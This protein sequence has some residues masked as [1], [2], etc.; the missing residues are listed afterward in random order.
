M[1]EWGHVIVIAKGLELLSVGAV[2]VNMSV[3]VAGMELE[4]GQVI[5]LGGNQ[6]WSRPSWKSG[7]TSSSR[8]RC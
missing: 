7:G 5:R 4:L 2:K 6:G 3:L 1:E 8:P